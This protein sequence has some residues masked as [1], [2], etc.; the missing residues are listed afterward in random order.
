MIK[1]V[2]IYHGDIERGNQ[3]RLCNYRGV[4]RYVHN[5]VCAWHI[6]E[7]DPE[8]RRVECPHFA[9]AMANPISPAMNAVP[10]DGSEFQ[11]V[12]IWSP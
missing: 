6:E 9:E 2:T 12:L 4:Q 11:Q 8:C 5:R 10:E 3:V 1:S 7:N